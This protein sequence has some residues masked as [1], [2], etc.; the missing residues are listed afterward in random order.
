MILTVIFLVLAIISLVSLAGLILLSPLY[1]AAHVM[2]K[3][4][5]GICLFMKKTLV[6]LMVSMIFNICLV[7]FSQLLANTPDIKS[8]NGISELIQLKFNGRKQWISIRGYDKNAPVLLF[9]AGGPGGTQMAAVRH[10]LG[11]LEKHFVVVNWDQPGSGKSYFAEKTKEITVETYISDGYALTE[12]LKERFNKE[13][14]FLI[15]ESWGSALG[16]FLIEKY[17]ESY[18]AFI[19]T[20]QMVDFKE[21]EI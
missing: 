12:Y 1:I 18:H 9:L 11:E 4:K 16:I 19:G 21:T 5:R 6:V 3:T 10:E 17:P 7:T 2:K 13:K 14:I 8:E 15:G 20:G